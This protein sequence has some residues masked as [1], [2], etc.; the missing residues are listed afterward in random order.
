MNYDVI[1]GIDPG[2]GGAIACKTKSGVTVVKMPGTTKQLN[3]YLKMQKEKGKTICFMEKVGA[4]IGE[5]DEK[6]YGII[7]MI[8]Q[9]ESISNCLD[10]FEIKTVMLAS[11]TWQSRLK[12]NGVKG[13][14]KTVRK[15]RYLDY[16][17]KWVPGLKML[18]PMGDAVC[19]L[20]CGLDMIEQSDPL[21]TGNFD[22]MVDEL[23]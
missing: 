18:A 17:K 1:I 7:K 11:V 23:F 8:K 20:K 15:R 4:F 19:I 16:A 14:K 5:G 9:A 12:L 2:K 22:K 6:K 21:I 10:L 3:D 13:E